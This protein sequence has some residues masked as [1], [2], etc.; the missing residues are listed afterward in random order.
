[1]NQNALNKS[2]LCFFC[3]STAKS[4]DDL[5][6]LAFNYVKVTTKIGTLIMSVKTVL[7]I[8]CYHVRHTST[9]NCHF[10]DE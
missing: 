4:S 2:L 8:D 5:F 1:M 3:I 10:D 7:K 6:L 9:C